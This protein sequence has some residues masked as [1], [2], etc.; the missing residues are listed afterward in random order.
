VDFGKF[1]DA[2]HLFLLIRFLHPRISSPPSLQVC[3]WQCASLVSERNFRCF[4]HQN[5]R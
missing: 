1:F 4:R 3:F 5:A 2:F